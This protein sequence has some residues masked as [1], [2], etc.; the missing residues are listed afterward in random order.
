MGDWKEYQSTMTLQ[1]IEINVSW[2][3]NPMMIP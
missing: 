2:E 3:N 1:I